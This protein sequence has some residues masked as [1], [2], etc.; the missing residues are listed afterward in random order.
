[1][2]SLI[3]KLKNKS[4][5]AVVRTRN[6]L[7]GNRGEGYIDTAIKILLAVVIGALLLAGLYALF[8]ETVL[9]TL[10]QR[11]KEMFNYGG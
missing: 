5:T 3:C 11:I 10:T 7:S 9:P 1:M 6:T 8:G 4:A 2:K